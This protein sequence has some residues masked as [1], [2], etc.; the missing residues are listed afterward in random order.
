MKVT[1]WCR[2]LSAAIV[3][4]GIWV[5]IA[6][7]INIPLGDPGFETYVVPARGYAYAADPFGAYRVTPPPLSA[8]VDD[9]DSPVGY[10]QDNAT[11]NWLYNAAY[12]EATTFTKRPAPRNGSN[13]A[14]HGLF[15]YSAQE[16]SAVFE[17]GQTYTFSIYAQNDVLLNESNGVFLYIFDGTVPFSDANSLAS[18]L[19]TT[20][21]PART[22]A[23]TAAQ[24]QANWAQ[25]SISHTVALG[26]PE[27]GHP[28]GVGLFVRKDSAVD[29]A[30]LTGV[31]EP[32]TMILVG[33]GAGGL[34]LLGRRRRRD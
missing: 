28:V 27:I 2:K 17:A 3:A 13:Q 8:W 32:T 22:Q 23:M 31:P 19:F 1:N 15:N 18:Q 6:H 30:T 10:T 20:E 14:M 24:S 16:T 9:L 34:T 12:A 5:P 33:V 11:S 21:I 4:A 29:D 7:A 25:I 26:A